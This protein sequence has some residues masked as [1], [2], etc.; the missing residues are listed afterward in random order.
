MALTWRK[1]YLDLVLVPVGLLIMFG[2]HLF[3]LYRVL[4]LPETTSIGYENHN[5]KAWVERIMQVEAKDRGF[6][7]S[8]IS[9]NISAA[10]SL[11]SICLVLSSLIGAWLGSSSDNIFTSNLIYGDV[12]SST[13]SIKYITLLS[14]FLLAFTA[15][16]QT[17]RCFAHAIFLISMPNTDIPATYVEKEMVRGS[18]YW[19]VGLR[20]IYFATTL[21]LW[22]FGPIPMFVSVVVMVAVLHNL[23]TNS[24]PLHPY[25]PLQS[26]NLFKKIGQG[27]TTEHNQMRNENRNRTSVVQP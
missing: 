11:S 8:V 4:N 15:F 16:V 18:N 12:R 17:T 14:C 9:S 23:D 6:A 13:V 10:T 22:I 2:Y 20:A 27:I 26:H 5:K 25:Q 24:T 19:E 21:L 1:E 7:I 3:L